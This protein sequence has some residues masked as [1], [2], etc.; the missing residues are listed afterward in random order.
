MLWP[1][2][3]VS[4]LAATTMVLF[5]GMITTIYSLSVQHYS[6]TPAC[7]YVLTQQKLNPNR[8]ILVLQFQY[9]LHL[10]LHLLKTFCVFD[11]LLLGEIEQL[12]GLIARTRESLHH[13]SKRG[14]REEQE[15]WGS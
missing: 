12:P 3:N 13:L 1:L 15:S 6:C 2:S 5:R 9:I 4:A 10:L 14:K 8:D 11:L 7:T